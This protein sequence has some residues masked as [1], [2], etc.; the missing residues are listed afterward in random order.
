MTDLADSIRQV[1]ARQ[2]AEQDTDNDP[3]RDRQRAQELIR[4]ELDRYSD[5]SFAVPG[6]VPLLSERDEADVERKVLDHLFGLGSLQRLLDDPSIENININGYDN[7]FVKRGNGTKE[8][9]APVAASDE[10]L[11]SLIHMAA[12][13]LGHS[14]R[15]FNPSNPQLD[16]RL[17]APGEYAGGHRLSAVM[18]VTARPVISIRRHRF[19]D[20][21]SARLERLVELRAIDEG[22]AAFLRAAVRARKTIIVAGGTNAGKT[23]LLRALANE[24]PPH[25]R[26]ITIEKALELGIDQF[27]NLHPDVVAMETREP[28]SEG[29]GTVEMSQLVRRGLRMDPDRVIVGEV[30]GDEVIDML[31][32]MSQGNDGS[33]CTVHANSSESVF[34]RLCS[35]AVQSPARL[36][37][38]ATSQLIAG[39]VDFVVHIG[40]R[41]RE[42]VGTSGERRLDR[43]LSSIREVHHADEEKVHS[44]EVFA[45]RPG[46]GRAVPAGDIACLDAL[47]LEGFDPTWHERKEGWWQ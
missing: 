38:Q 28:N 3:R 8:R 18:S 1:V 43:F 23:T 19:L 37:R 21:A 44:T 40:Q 33:L 6:A 25:E 47:V 42:I 10:E 15:Q 20:E 14:E 7:V 4:R 13:Y 35:Y 24:I 45:P 34:Q 36:P 17:G 46:D 30:L 26:L 5:H 12:S 32:A 41:H 29:R 31:N 2:L 39:A 27:T 11:I 22:I 9:I 16:L